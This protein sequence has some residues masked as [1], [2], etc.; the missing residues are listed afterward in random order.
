MLCTVQARSRSKEFTLTAT[1]TRVDHIVSAWLSGAET[2]YGECNPA[3]PR[4]V[5]GAE[6]EAALTDATDA[7]MTG[8]SSCTGSMQS[9]C[10]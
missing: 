3:G 6:G 10:C 8:C 2:A 1:A 4:F 9:Y 5:G 7:L